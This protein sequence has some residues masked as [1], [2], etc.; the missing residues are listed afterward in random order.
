MNARAFLRQGQSLFRGLLASSITSRVSATAAA[1]TLAPQATM[2]IAQKMSALHPTKGVEPTFHI[3]P[4]AGILD[5]EDWT[6]PWRNLFSNW[7][8][9]Q[10]KYCTFMISFNQLLY[11][12][13]INL[14]M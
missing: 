13:V 5:A 8:E 6:C 1:M 10:G 12:Y 11:T 14:R 9:F 4:S 2:S 7:T 3:P